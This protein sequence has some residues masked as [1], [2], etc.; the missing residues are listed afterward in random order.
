MLKRL[1]GDT[2]DM[3]SLLGFGCM[4]FPEKDGVIEQDKV[5]EMVDY[6]ISHGVNY[7]DTAYV[8]GDGKSERA[9]STALK[10]YPRDSY[11]LTDKLPL[12][13]CNKR[14]D[15]ERIFNESLNRL[16]TDYIDFYLI[17]AMDKGKYEKMMEFDA[18]SFVEEKRREGKIR[19]VGFSFHDDKAF[20]EKMLNTH[21]WDFCQLQLNYY[22]WNNFKAEELYKLTEEKNV[23]VIVME[24]IRGGSLA[25]PPKAVREIFKEVNDNE[26]AAWAL[27]FV[28]SL[29]NVKV[30]LS[31]MSDFTQV[32]QNIETLG[33]FDVVN[34]DEKEALESAVKYMNS[35]DIIPCTGCEYCLPCPKGVKIPGVFRA[36]NNYISFENDEELKKQATS[37]LKDNGPEICVKCGLCK[38]KC[39]QH[40]DIPN[41][42]SKYIN[43]CEQKKIK[44]GK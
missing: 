3:A 41:M 15:M 26:P 35:L 33:N 20:L 16:D 23:P 7:F 17:H 40:I 37:E 42:F 34:D 27:K 1:V 38:K 31:G 9:I 5:N 25:N 18:I 14:E 11:F 4:R 29:P 39:P 30:I 44:I 22:D 32:K 12:W 19:N 21:D 43:L 2:G 13:I 10:K 28:A 36:Y 8:Y 6:A 24:P